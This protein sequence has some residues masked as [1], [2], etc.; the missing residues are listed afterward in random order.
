VAI[1]RFRR[2]VRSD[3]FSPLEPNPRRRLGRSS[4]TPSSRDR[5]VCPASTTPSQ[6]VPTS[7]S[8]TAQP[9]Q[10][11]YRKYSRQCN[12]L[13]SGGNSLRATGRG[14][15]DTVEGHPTP[16][17]G[18]RGDIPAH[19]R[20]GEEGPSAVFITGY[21]SDKLT[22]PSMSDAG[23]EDRRRRGLRAHRRHQEVREG[24]SGTR[25]AACFSAGCV[26]AEPGSGPRASFSRAQVETTLAASTA[27]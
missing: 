10:P 6:D 5:G 11:G 17:A 14:G 16:F 3:A 19:P 26:V 27:T 20:G 23:V 1:H 8:V 13:F 21:R 18:W 7:S 24:G 9:G 22:Q 25:T 15:G 12:A 2:L 4:V